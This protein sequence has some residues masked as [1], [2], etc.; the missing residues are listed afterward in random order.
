MRFK[1]FTDLSQW[2]VQ[3]HTV[4]H[5]HHHWGTVIRLH[6]KIPLELFGEVIFKFLHALLQSFVD[7]GATRVREEFLKPDQD[8]EGRR[9]FTIHLLLLKKP[10]G[11]SNIVSKSLISLL[12]MVMV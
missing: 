3:D 5:L 9:T 7:V 4:W 2:S 1:E 10:Q 8:V 12:K 11:Q 6:V